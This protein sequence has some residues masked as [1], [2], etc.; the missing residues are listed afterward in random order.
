MGLESSGSGHWGSQRMP[1]PP[2]LFLVVN[3]IKNS[4]WRRALGECSELS[5]LN[6]SKDNLI[7]VDQGHDLHMWDRMCLVYYA[8][9][10]AHVV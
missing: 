6:I 8:C 7:Y 5:D 2:L 10:I 1:P 3:Q 4:R 9:A